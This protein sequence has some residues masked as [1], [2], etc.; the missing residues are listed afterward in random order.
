MLRYLMPPGAA[1]PIMGGRGLGERPIQES[2][3]LALGTHQRALIEL[4]YEGVSI[5]QVLERRL[6]RAAH[7]RRATTADVLEAV[8]DAIRYL[9]SARLAGELGHRALEV[10]A[11]ERTVDG[12]PEVLRRARRLLA[13]YRTN[14]AGLPSWIES[15]VTTGYAHY[16]TLLPMAFADEDATVGQVA[17][18]LGFLFGM[19]ALALSLGCDRA[20]LE[21]AVAQSHPEEPT[22]VALSWAAQLQL[23]RLSRADLRAR[24]DNLLANTL[25]LPAYPRYLSGFVHALEPAPGLVDF[26]VEAMSNAFTRLPDALLLPWLPTLISTL[27]SQGARFVPLLV[28]EAARLLPGRLPALDEWTAPWLAAPEPVVALGARRG[29]GGVALLATH[30]ATCDAVAA[31]LGCAGP[32]EPAAT[33]VALL[34]RYPDTAAALEALFASR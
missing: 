31:L 9:R 26:V 14:E 28:R 33:P 5:E 11:T 27:R 18:M 8:E 22:K 4:G 24:C 29:A 23:G 13:Y 16:C 17:A 10:L 3:D 32:W 2:W 34:D 20:Q 21:L 1:R 30:P 12:A 7:D 6:R 15:F 19:E 25:T